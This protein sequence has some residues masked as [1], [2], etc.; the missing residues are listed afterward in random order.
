[1]RPR[2]TWQHRGLDLA[3]RAEVLVGAAAIFA[4]LAGLSARAPDAMT[5]WL[6]EAAER[7]LSVLRARYRP[8]AE[9]DHQIS[10]AEGGGSIPIN[11]HQA[12][13]TVT[14]RIDEVLP[15]PGTWVE[16]AAPVRSDLNDDPVPLREPHTPQITPLALELRTMAAQAIPSAPW[17]IKA[18][19]IPWLAR[20]G[21]RLQIWNWRLRGRL[22]AGCAG[23]APGPVISSV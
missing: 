21:P 10:G 19:Q 13:H 15:G 16:T 23:G 14:L 11:W 22:A 17:P 6:S 9:T 12:A 8:P 4:D 2:A 3:L 20:S 7:Q 1:M 5:G 18:W